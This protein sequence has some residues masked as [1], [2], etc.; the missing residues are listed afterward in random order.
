M[1]AVVGGPWHDSGVKTRIEALW[2][3]PLLFAH[4]G[5]KAHV[6]ENTI[7]AFELAVKLGATGLETDVWLSRDSKLVLDHDGWHSRLARRRIADTDRAELRDHICTLD[8]LY[9]AVGT[10]LPLSVD[11]KDA[12]AFEP[13][14]ALARDR[15]SL[16]RLWICHGDRARLD[17]WRDQAPDA[18]LVHST[19]LGSLAS[20][21]ERHA[22]ELAAARID[23]VNLRQEQWSGG[24]TTLYHRFGILCFGWDAQHERQISALIDLGI[25]ALYSDYS[26]RMAAVAAALRRPTAGQ[27]R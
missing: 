8:E 7:E 9:D 5:A 13:V 21:P 16:E 3:P 10:R 20:T 26:D 25:D 18:R 1:R 24:L 11:L 22:A 2:K 12:A 23:A 27:D 6:R 17:R 15:E 19:S 14:V 4:R